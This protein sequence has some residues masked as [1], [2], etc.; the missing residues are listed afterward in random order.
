MPINSAIAG[1]RKS[2]NYSSIAIKKDKDSDGSKKPIKPVPKKALQLEIGKSYFQFE[3]KEKQFYPEFNMTAFLLE[4]ERLHT[5]YMHIQRNDLNNVFSVNFRTPVMNSSG[6][7]H[8][9]EHLVLCGSKKFPV[10]DPFFKMLNRSLATFMNAMTGPDYTLY[11]F[12][13]TNEKDFRNLQKVYLDAVFSPNLRQLDFLQEGWRLEQTNLADVQSDITI[14]GVVFNEMKGAFATNNMILNYGIMNHLLP[15]H[16]YGHVSGGWPLA[17]PRLTWEDLVDFHKKHY[18]PSNARIFS[19][20]SFDVGQSLQYVNDEYL[21]KYEPINAEFSKVPEQPRWTKPHEANVTCR[22]DSIGAPIEKQFQIAIGYVM[23]DITN[24]YE[25]LLLNVI[26]ELLVKGPNSAFYKTLIEPNVIGGSFGQTT[27]FDPQLRDTTFVV[28]LQNINSKDFELIE[29]L[30]VE[31]VND[32]IEKGFDR[33]HVQSILNNIELQIKHQS[34]QF[35]LHLL[36]SITPPWNHDSNMTDALNLS[37]HFNKLKDNLKDSKYLQNKV[38][39]YFRENSHRL[40]IRMMPNENYENEILEA[41][42]QLIEEKTANL[43]DNERQK[44]YE[45]ANKLLHEQREPVNN[46]DLLPCL[47]M[48]DI[49]HDIEDLNIQKIIKQNIPTQVTLVDTNG[50]VYLQGVCYANNLND[51]E[52]MLLPLL[53]HIFAKMGTKNYNYGDFDKFIN[54]KTS[55]V[56]F[57]LHF[58]PHI[59]EVNLYELGVSFES[60]CLEQNTED[61][62]GILKELLLNFELLD[63]QRFSVL[64]DEYVAELTADIAQTGHLFAMQS[65]SSLV[66]KGN[67]LRAKLCGLEHIEYTKKLCA[68][69]NPEEILTKLQSTANRLFTDTAMKFALNMSERSRTSVLQKFDSFANDISASIDKK[70]HATVPKWIQGGQ[71]SGEKGLI[72]C[73]HNVVNL[74]VNYCAKS[75]LSV[76]YE[77]KLYPSLR[78]LAKLLSSKYLLPTVR[79]QNGAYGAGAK[80]DIDGLFN[81]FSYRD[82]FNRK[83]LDAFDSSLEWLNNN[84][85]TITKQDIFEAKLGVLQTIDAPIAAGMKGLNEFKYGITPEIFQKQRNR[86]IATNK[87]RLMKCA[88]K[89]LKETVYELNTSGKCVLGPAD[90]SL[91]KDGE[92]WKINNFANMD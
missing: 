63:I 65:S 58:I 54:L 90:D 91:K 2:R 14:K 33:D 66:M 39:H 55:G 37:K 51:E 45:T 75:L 21:S 78:V 52:K 10:R 50:I 5:K 70:V 73:V 27:G 82:P 59:D 13:S 81:F 23:A 30:F 34:A 25:T 60:Y 12:S 24:A 71:I 77:N 72:P 53:T 80:I 29:K 11:P 62:F 57:N 18:H 83:T 15:D 47:S 28:A 41:E 31:T 89:Y 1:F 79:E 43:T 69:H 26:S 38:K 46:I 74:P 67:H 56:S 48:N 44:I 17:I 40:T 8:I 9:L 35:G 22:F 84:W 64:L 6:L 92:N 32:V 3:C 86:I 19:Y 49:S 87:E 61:M 36:F 42:K 4:H 76:P 20:G 88:Q 16:T 85:S 68:Q 7:P